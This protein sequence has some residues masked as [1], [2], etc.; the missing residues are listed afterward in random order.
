MDYSCMAE[1]LDGKYREVFEKTEIYGVIREVRTEVQDDLMMNLYDILVTAQAEGKPVEKIVGSDMEKFCAEYFQNYDIR[2]RMKCFPASLY[3]MMLGVFL[4]ELLSFFSLEESVDIFHAQSDI[5]PYLVGIGLSFAVTMIADVF[6]RPLLFRIRIRPIIYY[7]GFLLFWAGMVVL[8]VWLTDGMA[9]I[10]IPTFPVLAVSGGYTVVYLVIRSVWRY[11]RYGSIGRRKTEA[12]EQE[13]EL[14]MK[15][16]QK[17]MLDMMLK[18]YKRKNKRLKKKGRKLLTPSEYTEMVRADYRK[19]RH[20]WKWGLLIYVPFII[21]AIAWTAVSSTLLDTLLFAL[22]LLVI[23]TPIYWF[24]F[25]TEKNNNQIRKNILDAC[26]EE[27]ISV[28]EYAM[29]GN[30]NK[31]RGN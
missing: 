19:L 2:E 8:C 22:V 28:V 15:S 11:R 20:S 29:S 31:E 27:G 1:Q 6:V 17:I 23:E 26:D 30:V 3:R 24:T 21:S 12:E 14:Q 16:T 25:Q 18:K 7:V 4:F 10:H 5:T 9:L 13:R